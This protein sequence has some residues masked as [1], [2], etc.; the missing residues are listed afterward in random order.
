M[1]NKLTIE[2]K[3]QHIRALI[4]K[5]SALEIEL[6]WMP[7]I[8]SNQTDLEKCRGDTIER[9]SIGLSGV[10]GPFISDVYDQV[11][12]GKHLSYKQVMS[13]RRVLKKYWKQFFE[14]MNKKTKQTELQ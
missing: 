13:V 14:M 4:D 9:N 1:K 7:R 11:R 2:Q 3:K 5:A 6:V 12:C 10:D 8:M